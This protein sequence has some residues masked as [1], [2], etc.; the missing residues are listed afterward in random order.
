MCKNFSGIKFLGRV[1]LKVSGVLN[2]AVDPLNLRK[3]RNLL[4]AKFSTFKVIISKA[5]TGKNRIILAQDRNILS[6]EGYCY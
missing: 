3:P 4:L 2:F 6:E 5:S 1:M